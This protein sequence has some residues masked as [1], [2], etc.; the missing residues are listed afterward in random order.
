MGKAR[1]LADYF[2]Y[3]GLLVGDYL[4]FR[5]AIRQNLEDGSFDLFDWVEFKNIFTHDDYQIF[6]GEMRRLE[7]EWQ[8][9]RSVIF[10]VVKTT[11]ECCGS[12]AEYDFFHI[13][14]PNHCP[15]LILEGTFLYC[16][17]LECTAIQFWHYLSWCDEERMV[18]NHEVRSLPYN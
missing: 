15:T 9:E 12:R 2:K 14:N 8:Q 5:Y 11:C 16:S 1:T 7:R 6:K 17:N 13:L 10:E 4:T 3:P 18:G